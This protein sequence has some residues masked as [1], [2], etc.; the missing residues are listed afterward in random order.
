MGSGKFKKAEPGLV[1]RSPTATS[2]AASSNSH[3]DPLN[4]NATQPQTF[5][6]ERKQSTSG[7]DAFIGC[8]YTRLLSKT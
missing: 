8:L 5:A 7:L 2:L 3:F 1:T 4:W 6:Q